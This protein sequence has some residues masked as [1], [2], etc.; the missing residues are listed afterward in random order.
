MG[1]RASRGCTYHCRSWRVLVQLCSL[2][3]CSGHSHHRQESWRNVNTQERVKR[4]VHD[5][6]IVS[7]HAL[8]GSLRGVGGHLC[9]PGQCRGRMVG[10]VNIVGFEDGTLVV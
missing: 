4:V 6:Q 5:L 7:V 8:G 1:S 10:S 3:Q 9:V 2:R